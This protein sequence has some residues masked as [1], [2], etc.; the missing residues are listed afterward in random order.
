M[1]CPKHPR[2][3]PQRRP[4]SRCLDCWIEWLNAAP[5]APVTRG[6]LARVVAVVTVALRIQA[7]RDEAATAHWRGKMRLDD[8]LALRDVCNAH[9]R[10]IK[11]KEK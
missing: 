3:T 8:W 9:I 2:Y 11:R 7:T 4:S 1:S 6:D 5:A 10:R